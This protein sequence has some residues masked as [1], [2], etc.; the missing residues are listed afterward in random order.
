MSA[1]SM[2]HEDR[3]R[4]L[5]AMAILA[6]FSV[7]L[8]SLPD[9]SRP[10]VL[11]LAPATKTVLFG[12]AKATEHPFCRETLVRLTRYALW[13]RA[14]VGARGSSVIA[15]CSP[16]ILARG[17][18]T[19]LRGIGSELAVHAT[20]RIAFDV[21]GAAVAWVYWTDRLRGDLRGF[22]GVVEDKLRLIHR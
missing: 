18:A 4:M 19:T 13:A 9:Q 5:D 10:D 8:G 11:R 6:G 12:E 3:R 16:S 15:I 1:P 22:G 14:A 2:E 7:C 21:G 20:H 17:W